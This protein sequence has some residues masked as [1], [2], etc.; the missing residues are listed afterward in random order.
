MEITHF[1]IKYELNKNKIVI[2]SK[3]LK[4]YFLECKDSRNLSFCFQ[5]KNNDCQSN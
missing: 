2:K 5:N 3:N 1:R 4:S